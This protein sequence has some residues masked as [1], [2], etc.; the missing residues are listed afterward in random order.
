MGFGSGGVIPLG[1]NNYVIATRLVNE[2]GM[3]Y[4]G[5]TRLMNGTT[6]A[7]IGAA[8][9]GMVA[10]DMNFSRV[11]Q[12][13]NGDYFILI[14]PSADRDGQVSAGRVSLVSVEVP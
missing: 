10:D 9:F 2:D 4:A 7:A 1:N 5:T 13:T 3:A 6:G 14:Q 8:I 11:I 12:S